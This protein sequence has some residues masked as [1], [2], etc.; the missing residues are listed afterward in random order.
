MDDLKVEGLEGKRLR[1]GREKV[2]E[3]EGGERFRDWSVRG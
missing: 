1:D 2:Q 3:L